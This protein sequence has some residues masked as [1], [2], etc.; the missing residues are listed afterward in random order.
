MTVAVDPRPR[1]LVKAHAGKV[2]G[3]SAA[4]LLI[5]TGVVS[6][7]EGKRNVGY[8]DVIG[9]PTYCYGGIGPEAVVG[10]RYSDA[11]C[12][13]QLAEDV[14]SHA[15][16]LARCLTRP[17]PDKTYAALISLS[18][19]IGPAGVCKTAAF[20]P[21]K[22]FAGQGLAWY[23]NN[24]YGVQGCNAFGRY[25]Y[26]AGRRIKGLENRRAAERKLCLEGLRWAPGVPS[27]SPGRSLRWRWS[28]RSCSP[29]WSGSEA[30]TRSEASSA[31]SNAP[32]PP[33]SRCRTTRPQPRPSTTTPMTSPSS[34]RS[35]MQPLRPSSKPPG[36]TLLSLAMFLMLGV[37]GC[38][39]TA[40]RATLTIPQSL[41]APCER[42][43]PQGVAT[44]GE[45]AGYSIK[46][47][48]AI[49]V[50]D[51]RRAAVVAIVDGAQAKPK[52]RWPF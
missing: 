22:P 7:W 49:A 1:V 3:A 26:A 15:A 14:Q 12:R 35:P 47:D 23:F 45:L 9:V 30:G 28:W 25:V 11:Q 10:R 5:A 20:R 6:V 16:P 44:V 18:F 38:N 17:L 50:C 8:L 48:A 13:T 41:R 52:K 36:L 27:A 37:G 39:A 43:D 42:P 51:A 34:A 2:A 24:G 32:P 29:P 21:D 19:N 31:S 4:A 46:Q 33:N 40:P